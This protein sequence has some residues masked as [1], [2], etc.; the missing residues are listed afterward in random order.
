MPVRFESLP[1]GTAFRF[2]GRRFV[3]LAVSRAE[4][5][6]RV[7]TAFLPDTDVEQ[8]PK[9]EPQSGNSASDLNG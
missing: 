5:G 6:N 7:R 1:I 9:T 2:R 3:K 4:D 8:E